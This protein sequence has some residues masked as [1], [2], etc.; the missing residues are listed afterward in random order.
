MA[1]VTAV[2]DGEPPLN[3]GY[4]VDGVSFGVEE[5]PPFGII[6]SNPCD[7]EW[8]KASFILIAAVL[9][10]GPIIKESQEFKQIVESVDEGGETSLSRRK[11]T[12]LSKFIT[13]FIYN[14]A[15]GRYFLLD[16]REIAGQCLFVDYQFLVALPFE[17]QER[18][19]V[20]CKVPSPDREKMVSHFGGYL[21]RIADDRPEG[22]D[23][24]D[25]VSQLV[26]PFSPAA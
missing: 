21:S 25:M 10:A 6:L 1:A 13:R 24:D 16:A 14:D 3:Q 20:I 18:L 7:L 17:D 22:S 5:S 15:I 23:A 4:L 12:G 9:P 19:T 11:W 26:A 2:V 8:E